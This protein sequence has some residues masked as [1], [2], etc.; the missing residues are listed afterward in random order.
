MIRVENCTCGY[1]G[2]APVLHQ[3]SFRIAEGERVGL[4]GA[5]GAG[6]STIMKCMVGLLSAEGT[7]CIAGRE[8]CRKELPW[9]RRQIGYVLQDSDNQMFM[10]TVKQDMIF[11]P[12]NYGM[13]AAEAEKLAKQTLEQLGME[14]LWD[15]QNHRLSGG[16]KRMAALATILTMNPR[17]LLMDEPT[18][19]L[20]PISTLK[21]EELMEELK[22][23]YTVVVV[24]HNMQQAARV[25]DYTAFFLVGEVIEFDTTDNIFSRPKD[26]RTEDYITGRFG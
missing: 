5:N 3:L 8:V 16:E 10:A 24:T 21:V 20:D 4:I 7:V 9:I 14:F 2:D 19:A 13:S 15:R 12:M 22:K 1:G 26:K 11:G 25:S 17:I 6:K 18:S 23:K